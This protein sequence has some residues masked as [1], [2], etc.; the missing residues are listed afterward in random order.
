ME[1]DRDGHLFVYVANESGNAG[2]EV[3]F[4]DLRVTH[5]SGRTGYKATQV[6]EYYPFGLPTS[7][8]WRAPGYIDPGLLYQSSYASYDSLTGYYDFLSRSYD[9][10]LGRF[11]AVDPQ[12]QFA[13][14]YIGMGNNPV[15]MVDPD[16]ELAF[17]AIA[18]FLVR[19]RLL[20]S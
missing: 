3:Y 10:V 19:D 20:I 17:L 18:A 11:F 7:N 1:F 16:G 5:E 12:D 9:P 6:N 13:S 2:G 8:S 4:D 14:G 15:M